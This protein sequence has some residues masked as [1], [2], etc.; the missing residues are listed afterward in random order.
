MNEPAS[1]FAVIM[2]IA[3]VAPYLSDFL[4][5]P[6]VAT[7]T[8]IG[9]ILGPQVLGVL[10]PTILI[11]F[12]GSLGMI[13]VFFSAG[14]EVN[15][16]ILRK[17][18][19]SVLI[20]GAL[21]FFL[22][23]L[24]GLAFGLVLF[25]Q[26]FLSAILLG[27][28]FASS[29]SLIIQPILRSDLFSRESA[30]VGRGG[31]GLSRI[32]VALVVFISGIVFP[33][34]GILPALKTAGLWAVYFAGL[35][36]FLPRFASLIIRKTRMQGSID[37]VFIL[38]LLFASAALGLFA[39][40]PGY[41]GA[42]Y[43]G[44]LIAPVFSSSKSI[45]S[46]IDLLGDSLFL[47]FLLVFIGA[48]ANF[49]QIP[50]LP[51]V[52]VLV[53]GS[54]LFGLGSKFLAAF[55]AG[56]IF[57][58]SSADRGLLFGFSSSFAAFSLAIASVA[59]SS[60]FF[61]QPL[62]S[63]AI[64][65]VIVSSSVASLAARNSGS[66]ILLKKI[67]S[68]ER[69]KSAGERIMVALSKPGTA[70]HLMEL[71]IALHGHDSPSP[72]FPLAIISDTESEDESRNHAETM[73]AAAIMQGVSS[74]VSVIPVSRVEVNVAH[75]ILESAEEQN[76][77]TIIIGWNKPPRLAN[78]FFGSIIDQIVNGGNQMVL[79]ARA[80]AP[81][82]AAHIIAIVPSLCDHHTGFARAAM[83]L[84]A[85]AKKNQAKLH[86]VTLAGQGASLARAFK[87]AGYTA[88]V[89]TIETES[90]KEIGK[91]IKQLPTAP[92][93]FVLLSA[94]PSEPS[95][96]PAIERLP[97]RLGEEFP[98]SNLIMIYLASPA[99][100]AEKPEGEDER[101]RAAIADDEVK[102]T[103]RA[104]PPPSARIL[105]DAVVRGNIRV[106]MKHAAIADGVFELVSSAFPFD[107]KQSSKLASRLTE[108]V[109]R[110]P[111]EIEPGVV[112]IHDRI[113]GINIP[114]VC[115]GSHRQGF[116]ISLLEKPVKIIIVIFVPEQESPEDHLAFL[117]NI[118]RLFK[119]N[120]LA[121]RLLDADSPED[122]L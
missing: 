115:L 49:S 66:S 73:L 87:E 63:G 77:D 101:K 4:G 111:I 72:L 84:N 10:E 40:V 74:Q 43:A 117:G 45:S 32:L 65:L 52:L 20:F 96:H 2:A 51:L 120:D 8:L 33:E 68:L 89:Q 109:Q 92:R 26:K 81:F 46:R 15:L 1:V 104:M 9:I 28:F 98:D 103:A 30:E 85:L 25:S 36:F 106:N 61:D 105:E 99:A 24:F 13:Y 18:T 11:Q 60:G 19:K 69:P 22:P 110:Q 21:T 12:I 64:I 94:R 97:H 7:M 62:M 17:H 76:A 29:G 108:I 93:L 53:V 56:K 39:G 82:T 112:L 5:V 37:A 88:P 67:Q 6:V 50:S 113:E 100:K 16:G 44:L 55:I 80:V 83:T 95:W 14:S 114:I 119:E 78:A 27:A 91:A 102:N 122:L 31:A 57:G 118:A 75:G 121:R 70:H 35:Y 58:Y 116:R 107:R 41:I 86:I 54:A 42:F 38:F 34:G 59:G 71:G 23:F 90:W 48:S 47:P 79:V 3:V